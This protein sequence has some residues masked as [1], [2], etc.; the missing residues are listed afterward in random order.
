MNSKRICKWISKCECKSIGKGF[1]YELVS[2][3]LTLIH[4]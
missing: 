4:N 3:S 2:S 1:K